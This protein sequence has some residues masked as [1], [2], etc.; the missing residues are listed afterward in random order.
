MDSREVVELYPDNCIIWY[1]ADRQDFEM[2]DLN[3]LGIDIKRN[4]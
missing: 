2:G 4:G 3:A 1:Y